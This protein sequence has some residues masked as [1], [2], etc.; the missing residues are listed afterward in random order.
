MSEEEAAHNIP[1]DEQIIS[2]LNELK[3]KFGTDY[4]AILHCET[5][6][7][8]LSEQKN[9]QQ[10]DLISIG[11]LEISGGTDV[12]N[13][14]LGNQNL[15]ADAIQM[16]YGDA[17]A[18]LALYF[19]SDSENN[20][21]IEA[22]HTHNSYDLINYP[23][24]ALYIYDPY[25]ESR[26]LD[27]TSQLGVWSTAI[28]PTN[29]VDTTKEFNVDTTYLNNLITNLENCIENS[30]ISNEGTTRIYNYSS[31]NIIDSVFINNLY[32]GNL[33]LYD[34]VADT[35]RHDL[36]AHLII[37]DQTTGEQDYAKAQQFTAP[38]GEITIWIHKNDTEWEVKS[39]IPESVLNLLGLSDIS[40][41]DFVAKL[42]KGIETSTEIVDILATGLYEA[43][44]WLG[45]TVRKARI[46]E[47]AYNCNS[48]NYDERFATVYKYASYY[49]NPLGTLIKDQLL[50]KI[51][52]EV[53]NATLQQ[54]LLDIQQGEVEF[55]FVCGL[56]NG[57][58]EIVGS[59]PDLLKLGAASF[60]DQGHK[61]IGNFIDGLA[62]FVK[63][64]S[65]TGDSICSGTWCA[66]KTGLGDAFDPT[67]C[68]QFS[69]LM[70]E[71]AGPIILSFID[72]V[73]L[74]ALPETAAGKGI[75]YVI[76]ILKWMDNVADVTLHATKALRYVSKNLSIIRSYTNRVLVRIKKEILDGG[77]INEVFE[78]SVLIGEDIQ[79][80]TSKRTSEI[81]E[82]TGSRE[83]MIIRYSD[84]GN[85]KTGTLLANDLVVTLNE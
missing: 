3:T 60:S 9:I 71:I 48:E 45:N 79:I 55:A 47:Y 17:K 24:P 40:I 12:K 37:T 59:I 58:V 73:A 2:R 19:K 13:I 42:Q 66:I 46:P 83:N 44:D 69:E 80:V 49:L 22:S 53:E 72:P 8:G 33:S 52:N 84:N 74:A 20:Q 57:L 50:V 16:L 30:D 23:A 75:T 27:C 65:V 62:N 56:W 76:Q 63:E 36:K 43:F 14:R 78:A 11:D 28:C 85:P 4:Y 51:T 1:I 64:D 21:K 34:P 41:D 15:T 32:G 81:S 31:F 38:N 68:C 61:D 25:N 77:V 29:P 67:K 82:F 18:C 54:C 39:D 6:E 35:I 10:T 26:K 5:C 70:G 7:E